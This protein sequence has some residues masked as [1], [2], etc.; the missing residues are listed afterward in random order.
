MKRGF[1]LKHGE[2][3]NYSI[4]SLYSVWTSMVQ[5]TTNKNH[6]HYNLWGGRGI[7]VCNEWRESSI[8]F[9]NWAK[10]N[11]YKE[12]LD[13]DRINNDG[14]YEP[15]NCRFVTRSQNLLNKR[16]RKDFGI[17]KHRKGYRIE[18]RRF[19]KN[20]YGGVS[21]DIEKARIMRNKLFQKLNEIN[22]N[23]DSLINN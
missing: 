21:N 13:I 1:P 22:G 6:P 3:A 10:S 14:N 15:S 7:V 4:S 16:K 20:F 2:C 17:Y 8:S 9:I 23:N 19:G 5:R 12:G 18:L 11:G